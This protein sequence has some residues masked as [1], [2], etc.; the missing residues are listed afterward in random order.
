M[1]QTQGDP[2]HVMFDVETLGLGPSAAIL[3]IGA[4]RFDPYGLLPDGGPDAHPD[5]CFY[6]NIDPSSCQDAGLTIDGA[7]V[8][9]WLRQDPDAISALAQN[10][11]SLHETLS[12]FQHWLMDLGPAQ[13]DSMPGR[14]PVN[15]QHWRDSIYPWSHANFDMPIIQHA[16]KLVLGR[17]L[18]AFRNARDIRTV[19]ALAQL[20]GEGPVYEKTRPHNALWDAWDQA[21]FV[22]ECMATIFAPVEVPRHDAD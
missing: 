4:V 11:K 17:E 6:Q 2:R 12:R 5:L 7:T 10:Q 22:Q 9:W 13:Q 14:F 16:A 8:G 20:T 3:S 18:F 19:R 21:I 1:T 15:S